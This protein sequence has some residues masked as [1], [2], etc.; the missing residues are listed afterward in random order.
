MSSSVE[1]YQTPPVQL[2]TI[3]ES[4]QQTS[5]TL[6]RYLDLPFSIQQ[7]KERKVSKTQK[8][9]I[10][11]TTSQKSNLEAPTK[12]CIKYNT[13]CSHCNVI[14]GESVRKCDGARAGQCRGFS[15]ES[16]TDGSLCSRCQRPGQN[17]GYLRVPTVTYRNEFERKYRR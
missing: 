14:A 3:S 11:Y 4:P 2:T 13:C 12:M 10:L 9:I 7:K 16:V 15:Q 17:A 8:T 5:S 6:Y 1:Q